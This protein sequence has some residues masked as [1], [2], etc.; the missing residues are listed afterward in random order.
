M[1]KKDPMNTKLTNSQKEGDT[2]GLL[3]P[4]HQSFK[5]M[6]ATRLLYAA[7]VIAAIGVGIF[8]K[9][10]FQDENVLEV[11]NEPF[12]VRTIRESPESNG[13]VILKVDYCKNIDTDGDLRM[14]FIS[15][16]KEVFLPIVKERGPKGCQVTDF[17]ILVPESLEP[18]DYKIKFRVAYRINPLKSNVVDE[19][20]SREFHVP[21]TLVKK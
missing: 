11:K 16:D 6:I 17:P 19:F 4:E 10:S 20:V 12:P 3:E 2:R 21:A 1:D 13:V 9:W 14:S 5:Q 7:L 8:L 15:K 18:G